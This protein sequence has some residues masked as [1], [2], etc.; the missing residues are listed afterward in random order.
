M[1][2][3][4]TL[5]IPGSLTA[6]EGTWTQPQGRTAVLETRGDFMD[7]DVR[8]TAVLVFLQ[9]VTLLKFTYVNPDELAEV[10]AQVAEFNADP[11]GVWRRMLTEV[12]VRQLSS[13]A[14]AMAEASSVAAFA[15]DHLPERSFH[16]LDLSLAWAEDISRADVQP[17]P[18]ILA[19]DLNGRPSVVISAETNEGTVE[20]YS[21][22]L[23]P[24]D[25]AALDAEVER[26]NSDPPTALRSLARDAL[27]AYYRECALEVAH[28][29]YR[30]R[31]TAALLGALA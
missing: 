18:A 31:E 23:I 19:V 7:G 12:A 5:T 8:M 4:L 20:L 30:Q 10:E 29:T 13:K 27:T 1:T 16:Y 25:Q 28:L 3:S 6:L 11:D 24:E 9:D 21:E 17:Q 26:F 22:L 15:S 14:T 2:S